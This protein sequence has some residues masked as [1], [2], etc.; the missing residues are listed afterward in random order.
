VANVVVPAPGYLRVAAH[1]GF[2][3]DFCEAADPESKGLVENLVGYAK[4]DLVVPAIGWSDL[5]TA[6]AAAAAWCAEVNVAIHSEIAAV[7]AERLLTER[8]LLG[9][10]PSLRPAP[11]P[12]ALRTVATLRTIRY[13][14]ARYGVPGAWIGRRVEVCVAGGELVVSHGGAEV[15][16]HRLVAPGEA[17]LQDAHYPGRAAAPARAIRPRTEAEIR[18]LGLGPV[19]GPFLRIAAAVATPRLAAEL[20][21]IVDLERSHGREALVAALERALAYRR[22]RAA[23]VRHPGR[24]HGCARPSRARRAARHRGTGGPGPLPRRPHPGTRV[25]TAQVAA[26]LAPDLEAALRRPKLAAVRRL[27]PEV[28]ATAKTQRWAPDEPLRTLLEAEVASRDASNARARLG[29]AGFPVT[30]TL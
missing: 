13:G 21:A 2:R 23:D 14:S 9:P 8:A 18:F 5:V 3:P 27:A 24:G 7:P 29:A 30:K 19:A 11:A 10:L 1:Y 12:T 28:L 17:S 25:M 26:P 20:A 6:N 16:R 15:A 4:R 22:F